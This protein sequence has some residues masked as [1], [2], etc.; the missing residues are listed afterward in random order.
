VLRRHDIIVSL[1]YRPTRSVGY[2]DQTVAGGCLILRGY[3]EDGRM[4]VESL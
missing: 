3:I 2:T 4:N 1:L